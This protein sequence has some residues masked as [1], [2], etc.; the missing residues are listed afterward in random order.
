MAE[1]WVARVPGQVPYLE[2]VELQTR[3]RERRQAG[4]IPGSLLLPEHPPT[5]TKGRRSEK[6][7][8]P[9]GE[10]WY[11]AQGSEVPD[12]SRGGPVTY[13][14]PRPLVGYPITGVTDLVA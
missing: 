7:D 11:W 14:A 10:G 4:E 2:A 1:L 6:A 8:L 9:M 13:P 3:L 5:Y 12:T